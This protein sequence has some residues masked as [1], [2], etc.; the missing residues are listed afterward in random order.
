M[1][2]YLKR[3]PDLVADRL[4]DSY[5]SDV[6]VNNPSVIGQTSAWGKDNVEQLVNVQQ[7]DLVVIAFGMNDGTQHV[8]AATFS[9]NI[10][11]IMSKARCATTCEFILVAP[12]LPLPGSWADGNQRDYLSVLT[13]LASQPNVALADMTTVHAVLLGRKAYVD[14][15]GNGINHPNDFVGRWYAQLVLSLLSSTRGD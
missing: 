9:A 2:P 13:A 7:P 12:M 15:T 6:Q 1:S 11:A 3:W 4:R 10:Q 8:P 5:G 14:T